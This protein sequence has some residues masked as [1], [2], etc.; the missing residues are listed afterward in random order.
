MSQVLTWE[1]YP[2][3]E[4]KA[5]YATSPRSTGPK[6][7]V[8]SWAP[9]PARNSAPIREGR[10]SKPRISS[11]SLAQVVLDYTNRPILDF[12]NMPKTLS[13]QVEGGL[14]EAIARQDFRIEANGF[15]VRMPSDPEGEGS[16]SLPTLTAI[17]MRQS[18]LLFS[19][20]ILT[21]SLA[22]VGKARG[23]R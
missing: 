17:C 18:T 8:I 5:I 19:S 1:D 20:K 4:G 12:E 21:T 10:F 13:S 6:W 22:Y 15:Q 23:L 11:A 16:I 14:Q 2:R 3:D 7:L 9:C